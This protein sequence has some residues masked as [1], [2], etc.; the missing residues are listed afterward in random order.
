MHQDVG[1][2]F[3]NPSIIF[4]SINFFGRLPYY[5]MLTTLTLF[6]LE[7]LRTVLE[8]SQLFIL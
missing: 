7:V 6:N 1:I 4:S 3:G 8:L 5:V 2:V